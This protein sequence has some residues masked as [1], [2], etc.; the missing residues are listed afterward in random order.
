MRGL[1]SISTLHKTPQDTPKN[2]I[3]KEDTSP[4]L[5][6]QTEGVSFDNLSDKINAP[7]PSYLEILEPP[8]GGEK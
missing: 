4:E 3:L 2:S 6:R 1:I 7:K 8:I 5:K